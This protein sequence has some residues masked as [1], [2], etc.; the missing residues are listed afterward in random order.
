[1]KKGKFKNTLI[2]TLLASFSSAGMTLLLNNQLQPPAVDNQNE[3]FVSRRDTAFL[4]FPLPK[5]DIAPTLNRNKS[6]LYLDRPSNISFNVEYDPES[7]QYI[8]YEKAGSIDY[9]RPLAMSFKEFYEYENKVQRENYWMEKIK[10]SKG[11]KSSPFVGSIKLGEAFDKVFGAEAINITPQGSAELIFGYNISRIDNPA[12]SVRNRRVGSFTFKEKIQMNVTGSIGDKVELGL[13][14]NTE[15]TFDFENKTKLE[16]TG[17][18]DEIIKKIEAGNISFPLPGTLINGS[19]SLFGIKT[20]L[21]FGK[22]YI[23]NVF[24]HQKGESS[25]INIQGGAQVREFRLDITDY[26]A[27]RHFFL[28]HFFRENYN[29]A[30]KNLPYVNSGI[31]I[32][33][34][35][36]WVTNKTSNFTSDNRHVLAILDLGESYGPYGEPNFQ[37]PVE[38][39]RPVNQNNYPASNDANNLYS[40]ITE[41]NSG[42]RNF[43]EINNI[44]KKYEQNNFVSGIHYEKIESAR[45]LSPSEYTVNRELGYISL[46]T[47][48][49]NDEILAV[50]YVYTY[51]GKTYKVGEL[52][53]DGI[54]DPQTLVVKLI[55]GINLT[56]KLKNWK[57]MMKNVYSLNAY[58]INR[59]NF[60]L[61]ILYRKDETGVPVNYIKEEGAD[62]QFNNKILL[63]VLRLDNLDSR[64][65]PN[66]DGI[67]DF[68][69]GVTIYPENGRIVFPEVEPFG[70]DLRKKIT[71]GDP[72]KNRIA[73][74]YVFEELYDST[75]T[76]AK[77][78]AEKNKFFIEGTYKS[79]SSSEIQLNAMNIPQG[80]VKVSAGGIQLTENVDYTVDYILGRVKIL[81]QGLLESGT[82][83]SI[84]LENNALF[85]FQTKTLIGTHLDYKFS[86]NF[87]VGATLMNLTERPLTQ[88]VNIGEEPISNTIVGLNTSY[89]TESNFLTYLIDK[90]PFIQTKEPS[91]ISVE[92]EVAGLIPG[93]AKAIG[94]GGVVYIDD[95]ENS[96][97]PIDLKMMHKWKL[98]ST[99]QEFPEG[100]LIND[101]AYGYNRALLAWYHVDPVFTRKMSQTP[102]HLRDE[103]VNNNY[104]REI[105]ETEI[106][107]ERQSGTGFDV[108]LTVLNL[109]FYPRERGPYNFDTKGLPGISAGVDEKGY[110]RNP[111]SRWG[112]IMRDLMTST[113]F[114]TSNIEYIEFWLMDP[115]F[116]DSVPKRGGDLYF[117]LGEISEDILRDSRKSFENGLPTADSLYGV[118]K[119]VWGYVPK[120]PS[121]VNAF[122]NNPLTRKYQDVGLDGVR[123]DL[124]RIFFNDYLMDLASVVDTN[125]SQFKKILE[126]PA[127]DNFRYYLDKFY[128]EN[129]TSVLGRYKYYNGVDGN[130]PSS[131][132]TGGQ[133]MAS[134]TLPDAEDIN[135]DNNL[136]ENE[137]YFS[138]RV[139]LRK[140]DLEVGKNF[141]VDKVRG[142]DVDWY[143][144]RIPINQ[145]ESKYGNI[146][147]FKSIRFIRMYLK[148]FNDSVIL[149]FAELRLIRSEWR[150]YREDLSEGSPS[151]TE[152]IDDGTFQISAV[153]IEK[154]SGKTPVNYILPPGIT[155]VIDPN[156]P[157]L[158]ELN[159][160]SMVFKINNLPDGD[161]RAAYKNVELDLRKYKH[162]KMFVHAEA[163][164]GIPLNDY[165][166][167]AFIRIGSD[168]KDNYYEIEVPLKLT[169]PGKYDNNSDAHRKIVW[170]EENE[171]VIDLEKL[172]DLKVER[173]EALKRDPDIYSKLKIYQ[174]YIGK[175]KIKVR[176][177]PN[178][179][180][181]R[182][183]MI[184]V[185]NPGNSDNFYR[186]DGLPKSAEVWFNEL[187][188]TDI[189]NKG[190]WGANTNMQVKLANLGFMSIAGSTI[191]P[192]FGSIEQKVDERRKEE[193]NQFDLS[194]NL[195]LGKFFSEKTNLSIPL[196]V[197]YSKTII[198]PEYYPREPDRLLKDVVRN[199]ETKAEKNRILKL[200]QD[201]TQRRS[202]NFTNI[203]LGKTFKRFNIISPSNFSLTA[204]YSD[205]KAYNYKVE[206]NDLIKYRLG[207]TYNY[208]I[209]SKSFEPFRKSKALNSPY[210]R[211][212]KDFNFNYL[213]NRLTFRTEFDRYYNEVK[214]R[215]VFDDRIMKID[216]TVSKDFTWNRYYDLQWDLTRSLKLTFAAVNRARI[217]EPAGAYD[218]FRKGD[219]SHWKDS[220]WQN[221]LRGG[222][223]S[224]YNHTWSLNYVVPINKIPLVDWINVS[225]QYNGTYEWNRGP[226]YN[227]S[228]SLGHYLRNSN[229][230]QGSTQFNLNSLYNKISFIRKINQ[231][232][233][234]SPTRTTNVN[235]K[236]VTFTKATFL[237]SGQAKS[238]QHNLKTQR[239]TVKV[240]DQNGNEIKV[241]TEIVNE[242]RIKITA[243]NDYDK[244]NVEVVG[245]VPIGEKPLTFLT[246]NTIR[247]LTGFKNLSLTISR[248]GS[249][250]IFGYMPETNVFGLNTHSFKGSPGI[251]FILGWQDTAFVKNAA[252]KGW[253][254]TD[255]AFNTPYEMNKSININIRGTFEP[256]RGFR[257][258]LTAL[259]NHTEGFS[260]Y[261]HYN[262]QKNIFNFSNRVLNGNFSI[263]VITIGSA[264]EAIK[265]ED[266]YYSKHFERFRSYR[267]IIASRL[268]NERRK[269]SGIGYHDML[270]QFHEDG[271]P[272]G[273]GPNSPEVIIPAFLAA[274]TGVAPEKVT[275][276]ALPGI[277]NMMP[278]W[279]ISIDGLT[280]LKIVNKYCKSVNISHSYQ[281]TY[282]IGPYTN[283]VDLYFEKDAMTYLRDLNNNFYPE[284]FIN[285]VSISERINPLINIDVTWINNLITRF[286][287]SKS[288]VL[289]ISFSNNQMTE[290]LSNTL[291]FGSGYRFKD[292]AIKINEKT[293]KSDL[294]LRFDL[295]IR[296][297]RTLLRYINVDNIAEQTK[298]L[299]GQKVYTINSTA[300]Y[301]VSPR[302]NVQLFFDHTFN[303]PHT[304]RSFI[305]A[306]TNI[307]FNLRFTLQ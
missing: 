52:T 28:S 270:T 31:R 248:N 86:D 12:L 251:P 198:N 174:K 11:Q 96:E 195:E 287:I 115:Y 302:F 108:P 10:E 53:T 178:L 72:S 262:R 256:F 183:I 19:Q 116:E 252:L 32:E 242:N 202:I 212:I 113:D 201:V 284:L 140:P 176:G 85:N 296:D 4:K 193:T 247:F 22:L 77:Q 234:G 190:G 134:T 220:V 74:K 66:P 182:T 79:S 24:S 33:Q 109:A 65:E 285:S 50:A 95:F 261:F 223:N 9:K 104:V 172:V 205:V 38:F 37:G 49:R 200:S 206:R 199:A 231:K 89:K 197:G 292:V 69:E 123:N 60:R 175:N 44:L 90:L 219:N 168:Y 124:E 244:V 222:R 260:E 75:Q 181:I 45:K 228:Y 173:D 239:I 148:N 70:S 126:D 304:S 188:L 98:A 162:L 135:Q 167:T 88:K 73:D 34:I 267:R 51:R 214:L 166:I 146:E 211:L 121:L 169:P 210:F 62:P 192:G 191:K 16:Y 5:D 238:I 240:T 130:S 204:A 87:I 137:A 84:S 14:Y 119:T 100:K 213:P 40:F 149:R 106:Y 81:N 127:G 144:F 307:G 294:N 91:S 36:V 163:I 117:N 97:T 266:Y 112:G 303:K 291:V 187:R 145:W 298:V 67:F 136:N 171:I 299:S 153:N 273:Y 233:S 29:E 71:G 158:A 142:K 288:R 25:T 271:Y 258:D 118:D 184:G 227:N 249:T 138:Y 272:S 48:L 150:R 78:I 280:R 286:E 209:R 139:S 141:I 177:T 290:N 245:E 76:K 301:A 128:D 2:F 23:T 43:A 7:N 20:E 125:S 293:Y 101:R 18:E 275:L 133:V 180:N 264:F 143:L 263:S 35:E 94:K 179:S 63:K 154:N 237:R 226:I 122:D 246:D 102:K 92:A 27:N 306:D 170:P 6:S 159:E 3:G 129:Q 13:N 189:N 132:Q 120:G 269:N 164:P 276:E 58:Q 255:S 259:R 230:I 46:N 282:N 229:T 243:D 15:A 297:I 232:Y 105:K 83:I 161:A 80:S 278:N 253:L 26:D 152:E 107:K 236:K 61:D 59:D 57:L 147:D 221:I 151:L 300:D 82:P 111:E 30:L 207:L 186:N 157:Q 277:F 42:I 196:F 8:L 289:S 194:T 56:P 208:T 64:N 217:D 55:K 305:T 268:Y 225:L 215:N 103:D 224:N 254:T 265:E 39:V 1:M 281:S 203:R 160:Q 235:Y 21:Q 257:I 218:L 165:D 17:K 54:T 155:R 93:Q 47:A 156:Q 68:I 295:S 99:P 41:T 110:L 114:E 283:Y 131:E 274:Y 250:N 279:R 241:R 185:R 216:S